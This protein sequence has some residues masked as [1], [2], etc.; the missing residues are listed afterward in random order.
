MTAKIIK[1][2]VTKDK[3]SG[4]GSLPLFLLIS[5]KSKFTVLFLVPNKLYR[6]ILHRHFIWRLR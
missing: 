4:H 1:I 3:F 2:G 6:L 5:K